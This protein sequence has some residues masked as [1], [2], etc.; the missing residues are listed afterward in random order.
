MDGLWGSAKEVGRS[1]VRGARGEKDIPDGD[2]D[3]DGNAA[4]KAGHAAATKPRKPS[5]AHSAGHAAHKTGKAIGHGARHAAAAGKS[6]LRRAKGM[7]GMTERMNAMVFEAVSGI[8]YSPSTAARHDVVDIFG[9]FP[10]GIPTH[11]G[12]DH[13]DIREAGELSAM[14]DMARERVAG[15]AILGEALHP[16]DEQNLRNIAKKIEG[17]IK[18]NEME[19][20]KSTKRMEHHKNMHKDLTKEEHEGKI[21]YYNNYVPKHLRSH[22]QRQIVDFH[23]ENAGHEITKKKR[24]RKPKGKGNGGGGG[25]GATSQNKDT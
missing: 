22:H 13:G 17:I 14:L 16:H 8:P 21:N 20:V 12:M 9:T 2:G 15:A 3:G 4:H 24:N 25:D 1:F 18:R 10:D 19:K 23:R 5:M 7:A 11:A 6:M